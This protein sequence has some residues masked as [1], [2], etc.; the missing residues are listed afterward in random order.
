[1][2]LLR[3][4]GVDSELVLLRTRR[5]G[6]ID[7]APASLA[8]F[9]H[10]IAYVPALDLYLDGTAEFSGLAEL[11]AE[12]QDTMA[13]RVSARGAKLVRTAMLA[14]ESNLALRKWQVDL[15]PDSSAHIVEELTIAGQAAHEWRSHYQTAG[16]RRER[17]A[18]V[19]SGRFAGAVLEAVE[20]NVGDRNR[21]AT[22]RST[23]TV[24]QMGERL[25]RGEIRLPASSR[26]ADFTSTYARLGQRR[27]PLVLGY[28]WR[29][30]E[31]LTYTLPAGVRLLHAPGARKIES[32]FGEFTLAVASS[33]D[34]HSISV[35]S[36]L[37]VVKNRIEPPS[38]AAFRAFLRDID[39]ALAERV[40]VG[41]E[42]TP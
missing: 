32:P 35:T 16:E 30:E 6:R 33:Q 36:V 29:H 24:P 42:G 4:V 28:P 37:L 34:G 8:V 19:W 10:A 23:V 25:A 27:W 11:P 12:D 31:Q 17:Y 38:Y 1:M 18:K 20:M 9:D 26:E 3:S 7:E 15:H 39:A 13:L 41:V 5:G 40:I 14:P 21:P 22:V 2:T